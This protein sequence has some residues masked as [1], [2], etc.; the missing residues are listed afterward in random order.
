MFKGRNRGRGRGGHAPAQKVPLKGL[1]SNGVWHCNCEPRL[2]AQNFQTKNGG[3]NHGRW[4]YTCQL[5]QPKRCDFF[6]WADEAKSREAAAVLNNSRS[7]PVSAPQTPSKGLTD[8][9]AMPQTPK[10]LD[11]WRQGVLDITTPYTPSKPPSA[12]SASSS[13]LAPTQSTAADEPYDWPLSDDEELFKVADKLSGNA[14]P[15]P[16][17][18]RKAI[19]T[20][21]LSTPG[22]RKRD[23]LENESAAAW[24]VPTSGGN[25]D[26]FTTPSTNPR[27]NTLFPPSAGLPSPA[28]TPSPRR[29]KDALAGNSQDSDLANEILQA[30]QTTSIAPDTREAVKSICNKHALFTHGVIK[31][32]DISRSLIASKNERITELQG[33]IDGLRAE[34]ETNRAVIRH[35]RREAE[36]GRGR[37]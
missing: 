20:D 31:G 25:D 21:L 4:F 8:G 16:E 3:K 19:K 26:V 2:P 33:E 32:R 27:A 17:T 35:L 6:L 11:R 13:T 18:P 1:F 7:E 14:M 28:E 37:G 9:A 15:P 34:R 24:P 10:S 22:K 30:L 36:E 5:P 29:F 12:F 23:E